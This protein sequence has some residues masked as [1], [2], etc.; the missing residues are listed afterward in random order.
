MSGTV[1]FLAA[2]VFGLT[3][4]SGLPAA[5]AKPLTIRGAERAIDLGLQAELAGDYRGA[6]TALEKLVETATRSEEIAPRQ[7]VE[8]FLRSMQARKAAFERHG[9]TALGY[10]EAFSTMRPFG[11]ARAEQLWRKALADVPALAEESAAVVLRLER[12]KGADAGAAQKRLRRVVT[13]HGLVVAGADEARFVVR[14]NIDATEVSHNRWGV[15]VTA[16][17]SAVV[18]DR[19]R[20]DD[21]A[22]TIAKR[23][24]ER[25]RRE[26][27]ARHLAVYRVL[28]DVGRRVVFAVRAR[29]LEDAARPT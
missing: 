3:A 4:V 6:E 23:R 8:S 27:D 1:R 12:V 5:A 13:R 29:I 21:P 10:G 16:E 11:I 18:K 9:R 14:V 17:A 22:G 24:A 28:G 7:R 15:R 19:R 25:R 26:A 2:L 20:D